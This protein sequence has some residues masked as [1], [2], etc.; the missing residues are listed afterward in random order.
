MKEWRT[1]PHTVIIRCA[2]ATGYSSPDY[3]TV[4]AIL[5]VPV[6]TSWDDCK[7]MVGG[8]EG[9]VERNWWLSTRTELRALAELVRREHGL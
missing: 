9:P 2:E 8:N 7:T 3:L 4:I 5:F 1:K 6:G